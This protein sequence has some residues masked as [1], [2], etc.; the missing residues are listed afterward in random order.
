MSEAPTI[1]DVL[2]RPLTAGAIA[3]RLGV[4]ADRIRIDPPPGTATVDD[5]VL[6]VERKIG[7]IPELVDGTLV[8]KAMGAW[9][10]DS[11]L[12]LATVLAIAS[13][14]NEVE[15]KQK[16]RKKKKKN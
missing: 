5:W 16:Q 3:E 11:A 15:A 12:Q 8:E 4:S 6:A 7:G 14:K 1:D 2:E 9:E 13:R 10:A